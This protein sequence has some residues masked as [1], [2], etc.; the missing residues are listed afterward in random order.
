MNFRS[1]LLLLDQDARCGERTR[2][3]IDM[4]RAFDC[5]LVGLAPT[6]RVQFPISVD[7]KGVAGDLAARAWGL[8]HQQ[9]DS[10][11][12]RFRSACER[13][14]L[15]SMETV[16]V[17]ADKAQALIDHA[18]CSDLTILGQADPDSHDHLLQRDLVE[19]VVLHSAR[20]TLL[21]PCRGRIASVGR[22]ALVAWDDSREATRAIA[23]ALPLLRRAEQ[24]QL[25][26]WRERGGDR[27]GPL[28]ER[29]QTLRRWLAWHGVTADAQVETSDV[30]IADA[31]L[32]RAA[33]LGA[34]LLVMGAWG[35]NRLAERLLGGA[36]RG[37]LDA[38][39]LPVLMSH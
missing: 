37:L 22:R 8:L 39:T 32:S 24:V 28:D 15:R 34:D 21:L 18:H 7:G 27:T 14:G 2:V 4:A 13:A 35:H 31:M 38:M 9:A 23:D 11:A 19:R 16:V 1:L 17:E 29:L 25:L 20:P 26:T 12:A 5:H 10:A 36:T 6:G 33:D 30:G 3:A